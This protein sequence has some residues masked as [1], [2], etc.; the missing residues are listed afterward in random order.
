[1]FLRQRRPNNHDDATATPPSSDYE[2]TLSPSSS[3]WNIVRKV[4]TSSIVCG[5]IGLVVRIICGQHNTLLALW[6]HYLT[7]SILIPFG[8]LFGLM[9]STRQLLLQS[10]GPVVRELEKRWLA[11]RG[12]MIPKPE[13]SRSDTTDDISS[14]EEP[15]GAAEDISS[16]L[17]TM[18]SSYTYWCLKLVTSCF[19]PS[20]K[21]MFR[22]IDRITKKSSSVQSSPQLL[23]SFCDT[24]LETWQYRLAFIGAV[25]YGLC[26]AT[27][28]MF[29][30]LFCW[31][32]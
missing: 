15:I 31:S 3:G 8:T 18:T 28:T 4:T 23:V 12:R 17:N 21:V 26:V 16:I 19:L 14:F 7:V 1:M 13:H 27:G 20:S 32:T 29:S 2:T 9:E 6:I 30:H 25:L 24:Y 10:D 5:C 11:I 22:E